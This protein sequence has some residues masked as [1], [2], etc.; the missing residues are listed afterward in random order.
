MLRNL[1]S[2]VLKY[3]EHGR[4][5]LG[6]RRT[7]HSLRN[8]VWD[9][10]IGIPDGELQFVFEEYHQVG[11]EARE[12]ARELGLGLSIVQRL[13]A[14][15]GHRVR[16][17]S[18]LGKGSVFMVQVARVPDVLSPDTDEKSG[19]DPEIRAG[20]DDAHA[21]TVLVI[22]DD[23]D[24]RELLRLLLES[25]GYGVMVAPTG[26]AALDMMARGTVQLFL[27]LADYNLPRGMTGLQ[28]ARKLRDMFQSVPTII[29]TGDISADTLRDVAQE[30][31]RQLNKPVKPS[32]LLGLIQDM[33]PAPLASVPRIPKAADRAGAPV[34]FVVDD[35]DNIRAMLRAVLEENGHVVEDYPGGEA[36]LTDFH[37]DQEGCLV[38][39]AAMPGMSG[40]DVLQ[41]LNA[42]GH[43]L[44][45][46]V[47]TGH[48]DVAMAVG[49]MKAGA[50]DFIEKPVGTPDL[51]AGVGRALD[52]SRDV[53]K[54]AAWHATAARSIAALTSRQRDVMAMVLAGQPSK[55]IAADLGIS[56]RTVENH[57]ASIMHKTGTRSLPA[58]A[59]LALAAASADEPGKRLSL[60]NGRVPR[61]A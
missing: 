50:V 20:T 29:L 57:R 53:G 55:N 61:Y 24:M 56:Q 33:V 48:G 26:P 15:L 9:T 17:R 16:L 32:D 59:R 37:P 25:E 47:V 35:D 45:A 4:V 23:P 46:I 49:A 7:G 14:L 22:E 28:A 31:C 39:D 11:N 43:R 13:G 3:T 21:G 19:L 40:L 60:P 44:P 34:I 1:L 42:A 6:C 18:R 51:L 5:L 52:Q 54:R 38:V 8:E 41:Q 27:V 30:G 10:G 36:F 58:L 12:R 2:N